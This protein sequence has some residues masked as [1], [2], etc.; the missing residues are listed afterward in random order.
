M[1]TDTNTRFQ[2]KSLPMSVF[3]HFAL[4]DRIEG[5]E[6]DG[7]PALSA[8]GPNGVGLRLERHAATTD[9]LVFPSLVE[10]GHS[11]WAGMMLKI[12]VIPE[13][14]KDRR[15]LEHDAMIEGLQL[16]VAIHE[17]FAE[18]GESLKHL[19]R[20]VTLLGEFIGYATELDEQIQPRPP[21]WCP[22]GDHVY[23]DSSD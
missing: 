13:R 11:T 5:R 9:L 23:V 4:G 7:G 15:C 3:D 22:L 16:A 19:G 18:P 12:S 8:A 14:R 17:Y 20:S 10:A 21:L 1:P 2:M 6:L